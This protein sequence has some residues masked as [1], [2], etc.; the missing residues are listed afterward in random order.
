MTVTIQNDALQHGVS[1]SGKLRIRNGVHVRRTT[2]PRTGVQRGLS[3]FQLGNG[4]GK[5]FRHLLV[6]EACSDD[7]ELLNLLVD[8]VAPVAH[9]VQPALP[10]TSR[11]PYTGALGRGEDESHA[12][13]V[14]GSACTQRGLPL[15]LHQLL[16]NLLKHLSRVVLTTRRSFVV[17][18]ANSRECPLDYAAAHAVEFANF[19]LTSVIRKSVGHLQFSR[20]SFD[21][22]PPSVCESRARDRDKGHVGR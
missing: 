7:L 18:A 16:Q 10:T 5:T 8:L 12:A 13:R 11:S 9:L 20:C 1:R 3:C 19:Q 6:R 2:E 14:G 4:N 22:D 21:G 17:S 15:P